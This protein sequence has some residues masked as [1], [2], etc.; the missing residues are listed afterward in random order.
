ATPA[1]AASSR[2]TSSAASVDGPPSFR[3]RVDRHE[4]VWTTATDDLSQLD[5]IVREEWGAR[6]ADRLREQLRGA[7]ITEHA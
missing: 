5:A 3:G 7:R 4:G 2:P 6:V 1:S